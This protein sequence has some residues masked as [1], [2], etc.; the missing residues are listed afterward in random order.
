MKRNSMVRACCVAVGFLALTGVATADVFHMPDGLKSLEMVTVRNPGNRGELSGAS[1]PGG[2][3]EDGTCGGVSYTYNIGKY[4]VTAGQ[5]S[6][7]LNAVAANDTYEIYNL[8]MGSSYPRGCK[9]MRTGSW[10]AYTYT[11][12]PEWANRPVNLVDW[13]AAARFV[14]WLSNGQPRGP[15]GLA[16]TEDGT[17]RLNGAETDAQLLAVTRKPGATWV[18]PTENEWYKAAYHKN[19]GVTQNYW[20]YPTRSDAAPG[21]LLVNPDPGN[22]AN[23]W[24]SSAGYAIGSPYFRTEV[25]AFANSAS[26]YGAFDQGGNLQEWNE[27]ILSGYQ[28]RG[29][30]GGS[31]DNDTD[32]MLAAQRRGLRPAFAGPQCGFRVAYLPEPATLTALGIGL[33]GLM[34]R[35]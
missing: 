5:F 10:G 17:Y 19:D 20:D 28:Q 4:E 18:I 12:A 30:R 11:V 22:N 16:T 35:R 9:I 23:F 1:V 3:G 14:N 32:L 34:R 29:L 8:D 13:G 15:Q 27:T 2:F 24:S 31:F 26:A 21:N 25:G 7:F 6:E 33:F